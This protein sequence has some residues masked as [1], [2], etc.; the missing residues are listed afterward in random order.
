MMHPIAY[1]LNEKLFIELL[2]YA[3][4]R[5]ELLAFVADPAADRSLME[6]LSIVAP[7][8]EASSEQLRTAV[9]ALRAD[10]STAALFVLGELRHHPA[11]PA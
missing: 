9:A 7:K 4:L 6:L 11:M 3:D 2:V 8:C 10:G 1:R 5:A